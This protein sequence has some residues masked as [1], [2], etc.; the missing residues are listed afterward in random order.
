MKKKKLP[1]ISNL[2]RV[3]DSLETLD[4]R[5]AF[6]K[7]PPWPYLWFCRISVTF[8]DKDGE[9]MHIKVPVGMSMLEA[10]HENDIE[11]EGT[12]SRLGILHLRIT[13]LGSYLCNIPSDRFTESRT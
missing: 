7:F 3:L 1:R 12:L 2:T 10:A 9:E 13:Q 5:P 8:V 6:S 11:L 4:R